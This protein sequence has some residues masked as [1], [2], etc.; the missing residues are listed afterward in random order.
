MRGATAPRLLLEMMCAR[1]LLPGLDDTAEGFGH[2]STASSAGC[3][4]SVRRPGRLAH[5]P[6]HRPPRRR[7]LRSPRRQPAPR[8]AGTGRAAGVT[9]LHPEPDAEPSRAPG[10][11]YDGR[12]APIAPDSDAE[13]V[14]AQAQPEDAEAGEGLFATASPASADEPAETPA[15]T[16]E[17]TT[18]VEPTS[19]GRHT[20]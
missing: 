15:V 14:P 20:T 3:P 12:P 16:P 18:P 4:S 1:L 5:R 9:S 17:E 19:S 2:G 10:R 7:P 6:P 8:T 13:P 11:R